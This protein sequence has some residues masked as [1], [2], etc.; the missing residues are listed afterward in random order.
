MVITVL[1][2]GIAYALP[3]LGALEDPTLLV[4]IGFALYEAW[5]INKR[6]SVQLKGPYPLSPASSETNPVG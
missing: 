4:M 6:M 5:K 3:I 2:L 1:A